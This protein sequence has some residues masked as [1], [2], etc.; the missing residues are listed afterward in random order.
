MNKR[1]IIITIIGFIVSL[2]T[3]IITT[4]NSN[5]ENIIKTSLIALALL[6][7]IIWLINNLGLSSDLERVKKLLKIVAYSS[8]PSNIIVHEV[9][10]KIA[11]YGKKV[12]GSNSIDYKVFSNRQVLIVDF[13]DINKKIIG[14]LFLDESEFISLVVD[15]NRNKKKIFVLDRKDSWNSRIKRIHFIAGFTYGRFEG[16][17]DLKNERKTIVALNENSEPVGK[18]ITFDKTD[19]DNIFNNAPHLRDNLILEKLSAGI[20]RDM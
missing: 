17:N 9:T 8:A 18:E 15:F 20:Y 5:F 11:K 12:Y 2:S 19:L 13:L 7:S 4:L 1:D 10:D 16:N 3:I 6:S 14:N